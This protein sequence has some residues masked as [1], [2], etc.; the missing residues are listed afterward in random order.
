ML[1]LDI[2]QTAEFSKKYAKAAR[3]NIEQ[4]LKELENCWIDFI[5]IILI[6]SMHG[7]LMKFIEKGGK[8]FKQ[9]FLKKN[10][11]NLNY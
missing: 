7:F 9:I 6:A 10:S 2:Y 4:E 3:S 8:I 1:A 5:L 11:L